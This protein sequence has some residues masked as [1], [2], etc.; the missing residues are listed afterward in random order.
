MLTKQ[1]LQRAISAIIETVHPNKIILFGSYARNSADKDS[2]LDLLVIEDQ[3]VNRGEEMVKIRNAIGDIGVGI[4]ILVYSEK[5]VQESGHLRG[6]AL[7]WALKEGKV[8]Y[9]NPI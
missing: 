6:S 1:S 8:L 9:E 3:P 4:D 7:Y 5:D 2:D